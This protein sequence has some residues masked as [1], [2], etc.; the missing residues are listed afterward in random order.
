MKN[1]FKNK[2]PLCEVDVC[3]NFLPSEGE[4]GIIVIDEH[5]FKVCDEC[6]RL[7]ENIQIKMEDARPDES[8]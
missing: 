5:E 2:R 8:L 4:C 6:Y 7:M 3:D 1:L